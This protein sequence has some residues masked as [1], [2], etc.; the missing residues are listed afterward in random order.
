MIPGTNLRLLAPASGGGYVIEGSGLFDSA[1]G[2]LQR[3]AVGA[4]NRTTWSVRVV[5]KMDKIPDSSTQP[6]WFTGYTGAGG[7][8][9]ES[10]V[11]RTGGDIQ[12][13]FYNAGTA[14]LLRTTQLFRDYSGYLDILAVCDTSNS[15]AGDRMRLY[16]NGTRV[17]NFSATTNPSLNYNTFTGAA[18]HNVSIGG[19]VAGY[20]GFIGDYLAHSSFIDGQALAP[21]DFGEVTDD[22]FW[23]IN[24]VSGLTF[25]NNGFLIEGSNVAAGT[26]SSVEGVVRTAIPTMTG[27][28]SP[29]GEATASSV[30]GNTKF[31]WYTMDGLDDGNVWITAAT[32]GI[33]W[34]AYEF[35]SAKTIVAYSLGVQG[36]G[37]S[38]TRYPK[39][40][41]FQ[42][43]NGSA[44]VTLDTVTGETSWVANQERTYTVDSPASYIKY[45]LNVTLNNGASYVEL[46]HFKMHE[47]TVLGNNFIPAGTITVSNDSPTDD[48]ENN[49]G[50]YVTMNPIDKDSHAPTYSNGNKTVLW[51]SAAWGESRCTLP[52]PKS[53]TGKF[54]VEFKMDVN[55]NT[56][57]NV[58]IK[59]SDMPAAGISG[60]SWR[61]NG[62]LY[63]GNSGTASVSSFATND[64]LGLEFDMD[65]DVVKGYKNSAS[66][67]DWTLSGVIATGNEMLGDSIVLRIRNYYANEKA[68]M[69]PD[70]LEWQ[71]QP[72]GTIPWTTANLPVPAIAD[73]AD[74]FHSQ[75][76]THDGS[77]TAATCSF[78]L[79]TYEWLALIK[80]TTGATEKWY[81]IDS[82]RGVTKYLSSNDAYSSQVAEQTDANV[83]TVSGTTFTL[84]STLSNKNYLVEFH[85]AG[86]AS[87]T[88]SNTTGSINT[89]ATSV[90]TTSGFS[91]STYT[92]TGAAATM[93]HGLS[94]AP[95]YVICRQRS[96][97]ENWGVW[98]IGFPA[99][100]YLFLNNIN[101]LQTNSGV[102]NDTLPTSS[103]IS[104]AGS[105]LTN[106]STNTHVNYSW[107]S[108][109]G[110]SSF[111]SFEGNASTDGP[112]INVGFHP[113]CALYKWIDGGDSW[114][115][116]D[117]AFDPIN[118]VGNRIHPNKV[119]I[120]A[121]NIKIDRLSNGS[122]IYSAD[123]SVNSASTII[124]SYWGG[125]PIQGNG[126]D[127]SQGR[128]R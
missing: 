44:Y 105:A 31:P 101:A 91:L 70:P 53:S 88:A 89:T 114:V 71:Y 36:S 7:N 43:W 113:K 92:G 45:R 87:A 108:V 3:L 123:G 83:L 49:Y 21:T 94:S 29:S 86:L 100:Q 74:H 106:Q 75:V 107:H 1:S 93:G 59:G 34:I 33:G 97:Q 98:H 77:S 76:V 110:Y 2:K 27:Y 47:S 85:K 120:L 117:D 65:N 32:N 112:M 116:Y 19:G 14:G 79:D 121:N 73:P 17:T 69:R 51:S 15:T 4:S 12:F 56:T 23:Q 80:N 72:A 8:Y 18:S 82:L 55:S 63:N 127:T 66:V 125:T 10:L 6:A 37:V 81:W 95:E 64:I 119:N 96:V 41:Q 62:T 122:K 84:G 20:N 124:Y 13:L 24:D 90:N 54:Y 42:G 78:N 11:I 68:T 16:I 50:D 61:S 26:D 38:V 39:N 57:M 128:A 102:W 52:M 22:G 28:T 103:V 25:G 46:G 111:G 126:T 48:A 99:T 104:Y 35:E 5:T 9:V 60:L 67:V 118:G 58:G 115:L 109:D 30:Y 40:W